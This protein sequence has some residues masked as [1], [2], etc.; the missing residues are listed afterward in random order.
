MYDYPHAAFV[1]EKRDYYNRSERYANALRKTFAV[2]PD[3]GLNAA[4]EYLRT[5]P[6]DEV[7]DNMETGNCLGA[8]T[9]RWLYPQALENDLYFISFLTAV[10]G[11]ADKEHYW[12]VPASYDFADLMWRLYDEDVAPENK[13]TAGE[14]LKLIA[15]YGWR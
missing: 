3:L 1:D 2:T 14:L 11:F 4:R 10:S 12:H 8:R 9:I 13:I 15:E 6:A 7:I 5:L